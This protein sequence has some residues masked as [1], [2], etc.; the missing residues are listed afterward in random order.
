MAT[1]NG[2]NSI[3]SKGADNTSNSVGPLIIPDKSRQFR[4]KTIFGNSPFDFAIFQQLGAEERIRNFEQSDSDVTEEMYQ[5]R[6][7]P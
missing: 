5:L 3:G 6:P 4:M 2:L 7:Q 1:G